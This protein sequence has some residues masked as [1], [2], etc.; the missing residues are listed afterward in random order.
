MRS[1]L[2]WACDWAVI[3]FIVAPIAVVVTTLVVATEAVDFVKD[4]V[5]GYDG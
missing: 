1:I 3:V 4:E 5:H 2:S